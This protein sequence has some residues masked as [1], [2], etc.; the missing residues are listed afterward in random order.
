MAIKKILFPTKF[1]ELSFDALESLFVLKEAGLT[2]IVFLNVIP[3][4]DVGFVPFGGYLKEEEKKLKEESRI[5]FDNWIRSLQEIGIESKVIINVGDPIH[6][7]LCVAE[8]EKVDMIVVGRKK[9]I[10]IKDTFIGS[11]THNIITRSKLPVLA[12]KYMVEFKW[13]DAMLTK[14]NDKL[15][16]SPLL[17]VRW[18]EL[19]QRVISFVAG[20]SG[21]VKKAT[22]F[23]NI[24]LD[25]LKEEDEKVSRIKKETMAG[26]QGYCEKLRNAGIEADP[27]IGAGGLLDE[28]LRVSRSQ[29][30]SMIIIGNTSEKSFLDRMLHRSISYQVIKSSELPTLLVP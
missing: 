25:A 28:I 18:S 24:D 21:V 7:I 8:K 27:H 12:S 23:Y 14:V 22:V 26:L 9:R 11:Y 3:R 16:E 1:R 20:L 4:E 19:S 29:K 2:E 15:F 13:D 6:E 10:N 30:S 17:I 5:R